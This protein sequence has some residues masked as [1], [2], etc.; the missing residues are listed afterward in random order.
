MSRKGVAHGTI[1]SASCVFLALLSLVL[2]RPALAQTAPRQRYVICVGTASEKL[3]SGTLWLY[4]YSWYGLQNFKLASIQN[5]L[6][7]VPLDVARLKPQ[8]DPHPNTDGYVLAIQVGEHQWYR[9][10]DIPPDRFWADLPAAM[11][12][13]G[14]AAALPTGETQLILPLPSKRRITLLYPDGRPEANTDVT[15]SVF[16][17]NQNHCGV[18]E[19]LPLG[20]FRTDAKGAFEVLAPL[21]PLYL[22]EIEYYKSVGTGPAGVAYSKN[23]G[24]KVGPEAT[25]VSKE[26][27]ELPGY[28]VTVELHVLSPSGQPRPEVNIYGNW[29]TTTCGGGDK[30]GQTDAK[31]AAQIELDPTFTALSLMIGGPYGAGDPQAEGKSRDLTPGELRE[32]FAKHRV[33]IRW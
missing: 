22:D 23:F 3:T 10:P 12:S 28:P 18:H 6:A 32:L 24:L 19:G 9:T 4:S 25:V 20:T 2:T 14:R 31:G 11:R 33:T 7:V 26:Q 1:V 15:V 21:V 17:W 30:I 5:G 8:V 27:W 29:N 16:L 13:L